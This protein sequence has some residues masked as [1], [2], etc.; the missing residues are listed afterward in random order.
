MSGKRPCPAC[1]PRGLDKL[2]DTRRV[3]PC[4][5]HTTVNPATQRLVGLTAI[6]QCLKDQY[7]ALARPIPPHPAALIEQLKT[8]EHE[9][10]VTP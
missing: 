8:A 7:D 10:T 5:T 9:Q 4:P 1:R 3:V 6:G 2:V